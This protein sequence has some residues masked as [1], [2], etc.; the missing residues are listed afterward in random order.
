M[1]KRIIYQRNDGRVAVV[2]P[3]QNCELS[4]EQ[5]AL[6][7][8]PQGFPF[9]IVDASVIPEDLTFSDAWEVDQSNLI[10]GVGIGSRQWFIN[11]YNEKIAAINAEPAPQALVPAAFDSAE[12]P[13][14]FTEEQK[15]A[16]YADLVAFVTEQ[17]TQ[18]LAQWEASKAARIE[19][20]NQMIATQEAEMAA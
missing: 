11:Q 1:P 5:I 4:I 20:L 9:A 17:N 16:A 7:D 14:D 8:V 10:D 2:I 15:T 12:F 19:Q 18:A 6:K 3:A 13:E